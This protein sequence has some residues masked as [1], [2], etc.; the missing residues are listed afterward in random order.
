MKNFKIGDRVIAL[1]SES[2]P[3]YQ[4]RV[5]GRIYEVFDL[6]YCSKCAIQ[7]INVTP[8]VEGMLN[9]VCDC[10]AKHYN[11]GYKMFSYSKHFVKADE[12]LTER[13]E[14]EVKR[15]NYELAGFLKS[16]MDQE[17]EVEHEC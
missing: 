8:P 5:K 13:I 15:E 4:P 7:A 11:T 17:K 1:K 10:G 2:R 9:H 6:Q 16:I 3:F 14:E 12:D